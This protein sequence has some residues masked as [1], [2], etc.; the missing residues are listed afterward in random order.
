MVVLVVAMILMMEMVVKE[1]VVGE[2]GEVTQVDMKVLFMNISN[3]W[4]E[5]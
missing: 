4:I 5:D 2:D 3:L 1:I